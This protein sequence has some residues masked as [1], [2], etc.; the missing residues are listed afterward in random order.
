MKA[1]NYLSQVM[2]LDMMIK[3]KLIEREQWQ[4]IAISTGTFS[5]GDRV[6]S[7]GSQ[8]KMADAVCRYV[9]I[10]KEIDRFIDELVGTK[11]EI[12]DTIEKLNAVEY[13]LLHL[14]YIQGK[15][16]KEVANLRGKTYNNVKNIHKRAIADV[17]K[18]LD[19]R[20][21]AK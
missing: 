14:I 20:E 18:I 10:E 7:S 6:Q 8:Q 5:D 1:K 12:V 19:E 15:T 2:K 11:K 17:Q 4:S 21:N 3:N 16:F 13:D 9:E